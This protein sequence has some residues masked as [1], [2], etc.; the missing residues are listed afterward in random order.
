M[1]PAVAPARSPSDTGQSAAARAATAPLSSRGAAPAGEAGPCLHCGQPVRPGTREAPFC[2]RGCREVH[3]L[4]RDEGL[5]RYYDLARGEVVPAPEP[6]GQRSHAWLEPLVQAREAAGGGLCSLE[7]DIQ[8]VHCAACVWLIDQLFRRRAGARDLHVN[9]ALGKVRLAWTPGRFDVAGFVADVERFGYLFGPSRKRADPAGRDLAVRIGLCAAL[10]MNVMIF[11]AAFHVGL[12]PAD[13]EI[14]RFFTRIVLVLGLAV[15]AIGG[16]PFFRSTVEGL[17]RGVLHLD[18]PIAAGILLASATSLLQARQGRGDLAYFDT[19]SVFVTLM[20]VGRWLQQR[21]VERNRRF[22]LEDAGADAVHV[23]RRDGDR[24][25]AVPA[26]TLR[27]GDELVIA[28]GDLLPVDAELAGDEARLSTDWINGESA[29]RT[30]RRGEEL[31]A[32]SFNAGTRAFSARVLRPFSESPL[33]ALLRAGADAPAAGRHARLLG[34]ISRWYVPGVLAF[35]ALGFAL[36]LPHS[37]W[38]ALDVTVALLVVTCPCALGIAVPLAYELAMAHLR[39]AGV[40]VRAGDLLDRALRIRRVLFD[41]TG[42][43]TLGR[44]E[45]ARPEALDVLEPA[46]RDALHDLSARSNHPVSRC[47]A[48]ALARGRGAPAPRFDPDAEVVEHPGRG[49]E[50]VREGR[51][52]RLG[53]L[54]WAAPAAASGTSP[55]TSAAIFSLDEVPLALL[56]VRESMRAD[57][58]AEVAAL[59]DGGAEV[60]LVSGDAPDRVGAAAAELGIPT[61]RALAAQSPEAKASVVDRLDR[62]D[63]VF[64]GDGVNDSL[65]FARAFA[66]GTPA[67]DR[68]VMPGKADFFL[69]GAGIGGVRRVLSAAGEL[70]HTVRL[71]LFVALAYNLLAVL[72]CLAGWMTPLRAAFAMPAS[73]I[74]VI[75]LALQRL[76]NQRLS[77]GRLRG[78]KSL[79]PAL[80]APRVPQPEP[81]S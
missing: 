69:L 59:Q 72:A 30:A 78:T 5:T 71:I 65:A 52:F 67:V 22:L 10:T 25:A 13:G 1:S 80:A 48:E 70:R 23:R 24:V 45:L 53:R 6:T 39:R 12:A 36:W 57:A 55:G 26:T 58:R 38:R 17:R 8:G 49:V 37:P 3:A 21:V 20:L 77:D 14:F 66:T 79:S 73:S 60:W 11:S 28:P 40:F 41:K 9:P 42:T 81:A 2:C 75:L 68:P 32:G 35:A 27:A 74:A 19:L 46:A 18:L 63:T 76:S 43:L 62:G 33:P 7:L 47:V 64:V 56:E 15:V 61:E 4:L 31:P 44:L 50:L 51:R 16:W 34:G 29:P 54:G